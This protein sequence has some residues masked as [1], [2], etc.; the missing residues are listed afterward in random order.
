MYGFYYG[1]GRWVHGTQFK[2][3]AMRFAG[4]SEDKLANHLYLRW[5]SDGSDPVTARKPR[6]IAKHA[7]TTTEVLTRAKEKQ[8][9]SIYG[10]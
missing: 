10:T 5:N 2:Y 6:L 8:P 7:H 9:F 4:V 1:R 3:P